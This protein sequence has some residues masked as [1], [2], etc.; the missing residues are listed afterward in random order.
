[1]LAN[2]ELRKGFHFIFKTFDE[3][4]KNRK[5]I[6]LLICGDSNSSEFENIKKL[7]DQFISKKNIYLNKFNQNVA[8]LYKISDV[9]V[10]PS[11]ADESFGYVYPEASL[12]KKPVIASKIGGLKEIISNKLNSSYCENLKK[13]GQ[14]DTLIAIAE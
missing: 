9:V 5:D 14:T 1:M 13:L 2:F 12:F 11:I 10:I 6:V 8:N 4:Y 3:I 7:R